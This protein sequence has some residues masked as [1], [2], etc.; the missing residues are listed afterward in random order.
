M[1]TYILVL[2]QIIAMLYGC[3]QSVPLVTEKPVSEQQY[4]EPTEQQKKWALA[5]A[6]VL[7]EQNHRRH[8]L[9]GGCERTPQNIEDWRQS[10]RQWWGINSRE[11][12]LDSLKWIENG[13]HRHAFNQLRSELASLTPQEIEALKV[14]YAANL[15]IKNSIEIVEEYGETFGEKSLLGWDYARY[16]SLCGWGYVIGYIT[17]DEAWEMIMPVAR[18]LQATF[19]SWEDLGWNYVVGRRF[20]SY[21]QTLRTGEGNL[22]AYQ[23]LATDPMSPWKYHSWNL[24]LASHET[25]R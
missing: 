25:N 19:D 10:L 5:T 15:E 11:D 17:E 12:L 1:K 8:D 14:Q 16:V 18:M 13:G 6:A 23:K 24:N 3:T 4:I 20:W 7:T 9:L 21:A 2:I 22:A